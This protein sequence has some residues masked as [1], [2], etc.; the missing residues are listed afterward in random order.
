M[1]FS[2]FRH[3]IS[4]LPVTSLAVLVFGNYELWRI[5]KGTSPWTP[6]LEDA[7]LVRK[8]K[9]I[10]SEVSGNGAVGT[11]ADAGEASRGATIQWLNLNGVPIPF[12][13]PKSVD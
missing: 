2:R 9:I 12:I 3:T 6:T 8:R 7:G 4:K 5:H 1:S 13:A 10:S 11:K